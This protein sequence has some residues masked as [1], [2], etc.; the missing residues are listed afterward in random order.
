MM[1]DT[2]VS[3]NHYF[4]FRD[5]DPYSTRF[6]NI[7]VRYEEE[8]HFIIW[9]WE[10]GNIMHFLH[11]DVI[12]LYHFMKEQVGHTS[13]SLSE[14]FSFDHR[15]LAWDIFDH[16]YPVTPYEYLT[17]KPIRFI[18]YLKKTKMITC[19]KNAFVG[20]SR[21]T[22]WYQY[23]VR[24]L[25]RSPQ[26]ALNK[27]VNGMHIRE[28][29]DW[30]AS[31]IGANPSDLWATGKQY[32]D[33]VVIISRK[34]DRLILNEKELA[35]RLTI[36]TGFETEFMR[37][38]DHSFSDQIKL[39][40][41]AKVVIGMHGSLLIMGLFCRRGTV[42]IEM[43]PYA[44]PSRFYTPYRTM[45]SLPGMGLI[46]HAW[47]NNHEQNSMSHPERDWRHGGLGTASEEDL[48]EIKQRWIPNKGGTPISWLY[49]I[50]QDTIVHLDEVSSLVSELLEKSQK[51]YGFNYI[52]GE[53]HSSITQPV[54]NGFAPGPVGD[55]T[56]GSKIWDIGYFERQLI[57]PKL[58]SGNCS[59]TQKDGKYVLLAKWTPTIDS[60]PILNWELY[61]AIIYKEGDKT[62]LTDSAKYMIPNEHTEF[63]IPKL[64]DSGILVRY[65]VRG[66]GR[67]SKSSWSKRKDC[68]I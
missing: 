67:D 1:E 62:K 37:M 34:K 40:R 2:T 33:L 11:D 25:E 59:L 24:R 48:E 5:I 27:T 41:R 8:T 45:C 16:Q 65:V 64:Y 43:F 4:E 55:E 15:I 3:G 49:R 31:R 7:T 46:Y 10:P 6:R 35:E 36:V 56:A 50:Y 47:E 14:P 23:G 26:G 12:P 38:E 57:A 68:D 32:S 29:A 61:V 19:F 18:K 53:D 42:L 60:G 28:Y 13:K 58:Y 9:R 54:V 63:E 51:L 22:T 44:V 21:L 39:M 52:P 20:N 66:I 30:M 17:N